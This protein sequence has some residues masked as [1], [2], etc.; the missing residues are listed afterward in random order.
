VNKDNKN[1]TLLFDKNGEEV[2]VGNLSC[3]SCHNAHQWSFKE[4]G[5]KDKTENSLSG[6]FLRAESYN[7]ICKDCHGF[8]ALIKYEYFHNPDKRAS[9]KKPLEPDR[10][11]KFKGLSF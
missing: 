11:K 4:K 2:N 5:I 1:Y 7:M 10:F 3:P 9:T 6:K 8:D